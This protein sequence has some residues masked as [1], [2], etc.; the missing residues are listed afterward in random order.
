MARPSLLYE[1]NGEKKTYHEWAKQ[2]HML[3]NLVYNRMHAHGWPLEKALTTPVQY[4]SPNKEGRKT[5]D[6]WNPKTDNARTTIFGV[7]HSEGDLL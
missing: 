6:T 7:E 2:F 4:R 1:L 3:P 5:M